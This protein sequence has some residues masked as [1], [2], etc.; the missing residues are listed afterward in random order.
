MV[1]VYRHDHWRDDE[2]PDPVVENSVAAEKVWGVFE[3]L[4]PIGEQTESYRAQLYLKTPDRQVERRGSF[5]LE[6]HQE[7]DL[8]IIIRLRQGNRLLRRAHIGKVH[9]EPDGGPVSPGPHIHFP[10]TVFGE[11]NGRRARSRIYDWNVP[12]GISLSDAIALFSLEINLA[13]ELP[14]PE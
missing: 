12:E 4:N 5:L 10:T 13:T 8:Q 2:E 9:Q 7:R 6:A 1:V 3:R 11:I 14:E